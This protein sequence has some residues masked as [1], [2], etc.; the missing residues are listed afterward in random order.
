[1]NIYRDLLENRESLKQNHKE[2]YEKI[3]TGEN[4]LNKVLQKADKIQETLANLKNH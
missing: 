3:Q 1:M 2:I 4:R